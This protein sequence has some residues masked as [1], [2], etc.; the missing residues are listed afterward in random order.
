MSDNDITRLEPR[1]T[2]K[3][4]RYLA[5]MLDGIDE[6]PREEVASNMLSLWLSLFEKSPVWGEIAETIKQ[7]IDERA[8]PQT[9]EQQARVDELIAS[10]PKSKRP[11]ATVTTLR[12]EE[13]DE[14]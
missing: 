12:P 5:F 14:S 3:E 13:G 4:L 2:D 8:G 11:E 9:P 10:L 7:K 1:L 6:S